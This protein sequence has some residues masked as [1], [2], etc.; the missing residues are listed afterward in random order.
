M[1]ILRTLLAGAVA[2][3]LLTNPAGA[4]DS[5]PMPDSTTRRPVWVN[6]GLGIDREGDHIG[7]AGGVG[8]LLASGHLVTVR[9]MYLEEFQFCI[10]GPCSTP[11]ATRVELAGLY[12][13]A[14]ESS[15]LFA[16]GSAGLGL[17]GGSR[18]VPGQSTRLE[19][20]V[21]VGLP[22]EVQLFLRPSSKF[23]FGVSGIAN[24]NSE[25]TLVGIVFGVQG[26]RLR[27]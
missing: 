7:L 17:F 20:F 23:G 10:F 1:E 12:G 22:V 16:S 2:L 6:L 14:V 25:S 19:N 26:G 4:Q 21:T 18:S 11:P 13:L 3:T 27:P 8:A 5:A 24:V 9:G 15:W